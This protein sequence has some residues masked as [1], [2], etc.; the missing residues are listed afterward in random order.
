MRP[1]LHRFFGQNLRL[2][3][4]ALLAAVVIWWAVTHE[5]ATE[6]SYTAPIEFRHLPGNMEITSD[7][8][9]QAQIRVRGPA[10]LVREVEANRVHPVVDFALLGPVLP[11][12]HTYDLRAEQMSVPRYVDIEVVPA[13]FRLS[14]DVRASRTVPVQPRV[15][16]DFAKGLELVEVR[17]EPEKVTIVGPKTH[18]DKVVT[19]LTDPIEASGVLRQQAFATHAYVADPL[20]KVTEPDVRVTVRVQK[21][22]ETAP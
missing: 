14:F 6:L 16:G 7:E 19:A 1:F 4:I 18:V 11:G 5:P 9:P 15:V 10:Q 21:K 13:Q 2:K 20:V 12:E 8:I 17:S 22:A 3:F